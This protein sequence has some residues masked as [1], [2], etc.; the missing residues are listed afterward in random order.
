MKQKIKI[1][2]F[3]TTIE[4]RPITLFV[5]PSKLHELIIKDQLTCL[6]TDSSYEKHISVTDF[7]KEIRNN[8]TEF[9]KTRRKEKP[10]ILFINN[11]VAIRTFMLNVLN[12]TINCSDI[13]I[14][15]INDK[16]NLEEEDSLESLLRTIYILEDASITEDFFPGYLDTIASIKTEIYSTNKKKNNN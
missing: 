12:K 13:I 6:V 9:C 11:E 2:D 14:H 5:C 3:T 8:V 16:T 1:G 7:G 15:N 4:I 10:Y